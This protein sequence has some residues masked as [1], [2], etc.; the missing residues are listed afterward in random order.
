M[1]ASRYS[2]SRYA[3][4]AKAALFVVG[5]SLFLAGSPAVGQIVPIDSCQVISSPGAYE[6]VTNLNPVT[7]PALA[8]GNCID[9]IVVP[10]GRGSASSA[11]PPQAD[12]SI[13]LKGFEISNFAVGINATGMSD[14]SVRCPTGGSITGSSQAGI[15]L[16]NNGQVN[17]CFV[18]GQIGDGIDCGNDCTIIFDTANR[19]G[20]N[21]ITAG[22]GSAITGNVVNHNGKNGI[23]AGDGVNAQGNT[24]KK[25]GGY[26]LNFSG[27]SSGYAGNILVGNSLGAVHGGGSLR[28]NLCNGKPC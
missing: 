15:I 3:R 1:A 27:T 16:G 6:V 4:L 26:G 17:G 22:E 19:N 8:D 5:A 13:N 11:A 18:D 2:G 7:T 25:N 21:G 10:P 23:S 20:G 14:V 28:S 24:A 12:V 9:V